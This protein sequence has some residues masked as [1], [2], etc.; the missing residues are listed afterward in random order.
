MC[1][2]IKPKKMLVAY[3]C[4]LFSWLQPH[5]LKMRCRQQKRKAKL[6]ID[7]TFLTHEVALCALRSGYTARASGSTADAKLKMGQKGLKL[8][9]YPA[10]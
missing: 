6:D 10:L 8:R 4:P 3:L 1:S 5:Y 9:P 2:K 7:G